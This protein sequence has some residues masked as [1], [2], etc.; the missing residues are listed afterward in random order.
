MATKNNP[1]EYDCY[2]N[3]EPDEPMFILLARDKHAP[4]LIWL[5]AAMRAIDG[6][7]QEKITE[8]H[9]CIAAMLDWQAAHGR[10]TVGVAEAALVA[11]MQLIQEANYWI[12]N[13]RI[14]EC[15][16]D[17]RDVAPISSQNLL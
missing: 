9:Q 16:N 15:S 17:G 7:S 4:T 12:D 11:V 13:Y 2:A 5:W 1:G 10:K 8:A 3:A 6:E 14:V